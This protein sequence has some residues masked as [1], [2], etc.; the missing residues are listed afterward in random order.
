MEHLLGKHAPQRKIVMR[1]VPNCS[2]FDGVCAASKKLTHQLERHFKNSPSELR[3]H[4]G[5]TTTQVIPTETLQLSSRQYR[6]RYCS[7]SPTEPYPSLHHV[8]GM[9]IYHLNSA[10]FLYL[11]H[12][13]CK[14][15]DIIFI[16]LLYPSPPRP[17]TQN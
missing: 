14:S 15:Q 5:Q 2:W 9:T 16:R 7:C 1:K 17:S 4:S 13:H 6:G 8:F 12:R 10:S 11:H 3:E